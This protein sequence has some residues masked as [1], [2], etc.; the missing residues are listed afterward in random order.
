MPLYTNFVGL[1]IGKFNFI[2][3]IYGSKTTKEY[4]NTAEG[5]SS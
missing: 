2:A 3:A 4:E 5:I 1:D